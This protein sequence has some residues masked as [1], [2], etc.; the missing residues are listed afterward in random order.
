MAAIEDT[1]ERIFNEFERV[2]ADIAALRADLN[3][4]QDRMV[5]V[6]FGLA[7]VLIAAIVTIVLA[8]A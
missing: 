2:H 1:F 8:L 3:R 6:G 4:F 5:Q 7:A